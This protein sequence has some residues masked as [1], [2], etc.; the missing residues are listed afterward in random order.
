[1]NKRR[2]QG[3]ILGVMMGLADPHGHAISGRS[4]SEGRE[5]MK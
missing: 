3:V 2:L 5:E 4:G 1:M